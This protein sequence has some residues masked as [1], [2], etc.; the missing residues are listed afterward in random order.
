MDN[1]ENKD[2]VHNAEIVSYS[3]DHKKMKGPLARVAGGIVKAGSFVGGLLKSKKVQTG[4]LNFGGIIL[5]EV[6]KMPGGNGTGPLGG[7][8]G[9]GRGGGGRFFGGGGGRGGGRG[10][11]GGGG[12]RGMG[13]GNRPGSGPGGYCVCPSCGNRVPHQVGVPCYSVNCPNCGERMAKG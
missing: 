8:P 7:G 1:E 13:G 5:K 4:L 10:R 6:S 9:S 3:S 11:G 12:G 2:K